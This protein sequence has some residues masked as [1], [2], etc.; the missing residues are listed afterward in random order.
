MNSVGYGSEFMNDTR[1][2]A[3]PTKLEVKKAESTYGDSHFKIARYA[4]LIYKEITNI[5]YVLSVFFGASLI[6]GVTTRLV[7]G[8]VLP[9][10]IVVVTGRT[11]WSAGYLSGESME[12]KETCFWL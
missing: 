7:S 10:Q 5:H 9:C 8:Q 6:G 2:R 4:S 1:D 3:R 11:M 12:V